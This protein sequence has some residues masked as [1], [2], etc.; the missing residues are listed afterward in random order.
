MY[1]CEVTRDPE[2]HEDVC[3]EFA[4]PSLCHEPA[5]VPVAVLAIGHYASGDHRAAEAVVREWRR[6]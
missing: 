5:T 6:L 4:T 2:D 3:R 1:L